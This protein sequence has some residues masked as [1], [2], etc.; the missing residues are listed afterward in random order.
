MVVSVVPR[1]AVIHAHLV[2]SQSTQVRRSQAELP[3]CL[4]CCIVPGLG[5]MLI[6]VYS[7]HDSIW[8]ILWCCC[9]DTSPQLCVSCCCEFR[10]YCRHN[11]LIQGVTA[12]LSCSKQEHATCSIHAELQ[13]AAM[14]SHVISM[15]STSYPDPACRTMVLQQ[16]K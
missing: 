16:H 1:A 3:P 15:G 2:I 8:N 7:Q 13:F 14:L 11:L 10:R 6:S 4:G 5:Q 9:R 12:T